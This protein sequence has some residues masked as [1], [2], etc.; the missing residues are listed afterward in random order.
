MQKNKIYIGT[1][2]SNK[3][4]FKWKLGCHNTT[5][6]NVLAVKLFKFGCHSMLTVMN[7]RGGGLGLGGK[8]L[9]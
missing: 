9:I 8:Y 3:Q 6:K 7:V 4:T 1:L 5:F 2:A